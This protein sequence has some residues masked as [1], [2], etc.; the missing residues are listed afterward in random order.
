[1][2]FKHQINENNDILFNRS[3][4]KLILFDPIKCDKQGNILVAVK[5]LD[6]VNNFKYLEHIIDNAL[7]NEL[8]MKHKER[9]L[10]GHSNVLIR[11]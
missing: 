3:K 1:M 5:A 4:S 6:Y 2:K 11:K 10:F 8:D 9:M 7:N